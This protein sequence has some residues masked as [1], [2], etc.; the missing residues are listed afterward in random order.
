MPSVIGADSGSGVNVAANYLK[1][2]GLFSQFGTRQLTFVSISVSGLDTNYA[3]ADS[4][5]SKTVRALQQAVEVYFIG[6]PA[7]GAVVAAIAA[8][9]S[10]NGD[11]K[12]VGGVDTGTGWGLLETALNAGVG[13]GTFTVATLTASGASIA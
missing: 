12:V 8:D 1:N 11:T 3:N 9:T 6:T 5:F 10:Y 2:P 7:S 13:S 4:T